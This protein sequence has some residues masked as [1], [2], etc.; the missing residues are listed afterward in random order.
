MRVA[1][2]VKKLAIQLYLG[3]QTSLGLCVQAGCHSSKIMLTNWNES[4]RKIRKVK[5]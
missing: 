2:N 5:S 1:C 3:C 4:R